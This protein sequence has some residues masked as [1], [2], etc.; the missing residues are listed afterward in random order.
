MTKT[1]ILRAGYNKEVFNSDPNKISYE[2]WL[3]RKLIHTQEQVK[4]LNI[5]DIIKCSLCNDNFNKSEQ[6]P[7]KCICDRCSKSLKGY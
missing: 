5:V 6:L 3:E 2:Y 7:E 4:K 1:E